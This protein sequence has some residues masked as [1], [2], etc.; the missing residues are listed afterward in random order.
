MTIRVGI[1]GVL[2]FV[3][4]ACGSPDSTVPVEATGSDE[5]SVTRT[6][7]RGKSL[8]DCA[9]EAMIVVKVGCYTE[10][11]L[12]E[13][14]ET[15]CEQI[16]KPVAGRNSCYNELAQARKDADICEKIDGAQMQVL[17]LSRLGA[18]IG[19]CSICDRIDSDLWSAQCRE[20]CKQ[21]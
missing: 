1:I 16:E 21:N 14:D 9:A 6:A 15:V 2:T 5:E 19:D 7:S 17:C 18:K 13:N 11:A 20:A 4:L 8:S 3:L 10:L 12:A